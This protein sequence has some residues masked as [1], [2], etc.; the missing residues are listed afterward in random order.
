MITL[1]EIASICDVSAMTVSNVING[2]S[3]A[4]KETQE[5]ILAVVKEKG[6]KPNLVARGLR[7]NRTKIIALI[8][9]DIAQFTSP[10]IIEG[11]VAKF[12]EKG[13]RVVIQNL[14][15]Y[16]RWADTWYD[17]QNKINEV[18]EPAL[19]EVKSIHAE[20]L[21]YIAGHARIIRNLDSV[22]IPS[23]LAY[24]YSDSENVPSVVLEDEKGAYEMTKYLISLGHYKIGV[25]AGRKDN[26]H[27]KKRLLG[28]KQALRE[29]NL[30][31]DSNLIFYGNWS[32]KCGYE[33][34][35]ELLKNDISVIFSMSDQMAGGV[36]DYLH[37]KN[38]TIGEDISVASF[39][40]AQM[41]EYMTPKLTTM[42]LPL[43]KIGET[44]ANTL[45]QKMEKSEIN[46][47]PVT[48]LPCNLIKR[49][50]VKQMS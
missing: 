44:A 5:K 36:Y 47:E 33:G 7:S 28:I 31:Y 29:A 46:I 23:V 2:K 10:E 20:G 41:A 30:K 25:M 8:V 24:A 16:S 42:E 48:K 17:D 37:E 13:Y 3:K 12:E 43:K 26:I 6:Y 11:A 22:E 27:T 9:E 34:A 19:D 4:S 18:L 1:K 32:R 38:L 49:N 14:R 21:I 40:N 50:S 39:D 35:K 45:I 15:F